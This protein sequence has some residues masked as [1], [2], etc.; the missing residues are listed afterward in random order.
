MDTGI[1]RLLEQINKQANSNN[2]A[3][4]F[5]SSSAPEPFA[6][7]NMNFLLPKQDFRSAKNQAQPKLPMIAYWP[8]TIPPGRTS[9]KEWSV[10]DLA[11]TALAIARQNAVAN[12]T[13]HSVLPVLLER[14]SAKP[15]GQKP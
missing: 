15:S 2:V 11:P 9:G 1:G 12:F 6:G 8:G 5:T 3:I 4:F 10:T 7:T 14:P 13:G